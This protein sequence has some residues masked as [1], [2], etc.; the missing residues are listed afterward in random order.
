MA[1]IHLHPGRI[2]VLGALFL[3]FRELCSL[4]ARDLGAKGASAF[5]S[6]LDYNAGAASAHTSTRAATNRAKAIQGTLQ[7][8]KQTDGFMSPAWVSRP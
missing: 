1:F 5:G 7:I 3:R 2:E 8:Q 6:G 4:V